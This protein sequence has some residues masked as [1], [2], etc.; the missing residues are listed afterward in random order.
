MQTLQ[1]KNHRRTVSAALLFGVLSMA[2]SAFALDLPPIINSLLTDAATVGASHT[3]TITALNSPTSFNA[4]GLPG[5]LSVDTT[6]GAISGTPT[7][8]GIFTVTI[9]AS[10]IAGADSKPLVLTVL[11]GWPAVTWNNPAASVFGVPLGGAQLNATANIPGTFTY[12][13]KAGTLLSVGLGQALAVVFTPDDLNNYNPTTAGVSL[14]V[15]P[16]TPV[17]TAPASVNIIYGTPLGAQ[18]LNATANVAGTFFYTPAAGTVLNVGAGQTLTAV[19]TPNDLVDYTPATA[20]VTINVLPQTPVVTWNPAPITFGTPLGAA[21]LD[22]TANVPGTFVYTPA[23]GVSLNAGAQTL[24]VQFIPT[25]TVSYL[26]VVATA[27]VNVLKQSPTIAWNP[28][29]VTFGSPLGAAQLNATS[30]VPG[31]FIYTPPAG[32]ILNPGAQT[33]SVQF[34]PTDL[35]NYSTATANASINVNQQAPVITW[36]PAPVTFGTPLSAAQLNASANVAGTF[37]YTPAAG[38]LLG[39]GNQTLTAQFVPT[40]AVDYSAVLSSVSVNVGQQAPVVTWNPSPV[41]FGSPLSAAQLNATSNVPGTF[42]YTPAI[43]SLLGV[44]NQTLSVQFVPNDA[45]NFSAVSSTANINVAQ[46]TPV[47]T[48]NPAAVVYG[49]PLS[50]AQLNATANVPGTFVYTPAIG[51]VLGAGNQTLSVQFVP[52]DAVNFS[53]VSSTASINVGQQAPV[54]TWNP[55]PVVY[56]S[57]LGAGQLDATANIP[58]TFVY[59]PAAGTTLNAGN[60]TLSVHFVPN[61]VANYSTISSSVNIVVG[62]QDPAVTWSPG[63]IAFGS[64]LGAQQLNATSNVPG[65]FTYTPAAGTMLNTGNQTFSVQFTPNDTANYSVTTTNVNINVGKQTPAIAWS[66]AGLVFGAPLG[67]AQLNATANVPGTFVYSPAAGAVLNAGHQT[68]S[69]Q[70]TPD[71][72][73]NYS[74]A[75]FN[76]DIDVGKQ[77]PIIIW[78]PKGISYGQPLDGNQLNASANV[79]GRFLYS[80]AA[81][82]VL[83]AGM[84]A[85]A[86]Q[87][88]PDDSSN[89]ASANASIPL[90]VSAQPVFVSSPSANPN[91]ALAG[92]SISFSCGATGSG[93]SYFWS[94]G[95]GSA[96]VSGNPVSYAFAAP[97]SY[98]VTATVQDENGATVSQTFVV[99]V[100]APGGDNGAGT[101]SGPNDPSGGTNTGTGPFAGDP[102]PFGTQT[103]TSIQPLVIKKMRTKLNFRREG[104]DVIVFYGSIPVPAGFKLQGQR[105]LVYVGGVLKPFVLNK[106]GRARVNADSV[107]VRIHRVRAKRKPHNF[108]YVANYIVRMRRG[109]FDNAL[110]DEGLSNT[111]V[112]RTPRSIEVDVLFNNTLFQKIELQIYTAKAGKSGH[113]R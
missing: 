68:L 75:S 74:P 86:L 48:W 88:I 104:Y 76:A 39:V 56:G 2:G 36:N 111:T 65:T 55:A 99:V 91:P 17:I 106:H 57:P 53:A 107:S 26:P 73:T 92:Q 31:T 110:N 46:Q 59:T 95:D 112:K 93:L 79:P 49:S 103:P 47:V 96:Q 16:A 24:S 102:I 38:T 6:S 108:S 64:P 78:N 41:V 25:D 8:A 45:V 100:N 42:V 83:N 1:S 87:F 101:G 29:N 22:A 62:K 7:T 113:S 52:D 60:Q 18:Q 20:T 90:N 71:D 14:N 43:G 98:S 70:F 27:S 77:T 35:L 32:T 54:I 11:K 33:L 5:G 84:Q 109:D 81:G 4:I 51:S 19:F 72:S 12:T 85:L 67:N 10:N 21:Q 50:A 40:D 23:A 80:P 34:V 15:T 28:A 69:V 105:F 30:D 44:G 82:A 9:T 58:G 37:V 89:Y 3:Y 61:D 97:G 94:F 66:P 63:Q 13:P